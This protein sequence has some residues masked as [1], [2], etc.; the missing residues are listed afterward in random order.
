[1]QKRRQINVIHQAEMLVD[2]ACANVI[3]H[4]GQIVGCL[5]LERILFRAGSATRKLRK[6][7]CA[8]A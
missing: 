7:A 5:N 6:C 2:V 3:P 4:V 1:L 8:Y